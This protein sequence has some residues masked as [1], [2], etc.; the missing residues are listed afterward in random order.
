MSKSLTITFD[1][2]QSPADALAAIDDVRSWW[3]GNVEGVTDALGAEW[4]YEVPDIHSSRFRIT[5]HVPGRR[6]AWLVTDSW[7]SFVA[8]KQEWTG[9]TVVF[10]VAEHEG[11]TRVTFT[12]EGLTPEHECYGVCEYAWG[13][14]VRG[15]LRARIESGAGRPDSFGSQES[16]EVAQAA[17]GS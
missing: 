3:S 7:L 13:E 8:D 6:V 1:V 16:L 2:D 9:T 14:Y 12:H 11:R 10:E 4:T 15:S 17:T 5:E